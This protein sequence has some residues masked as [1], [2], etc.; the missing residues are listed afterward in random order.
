MSTT[1]KVIIAIVII[2]LIVGAIVWYKKSKAKPLAK[3]DKIDVGTIGT[4]G[5]EGTRA[6]AEV[7]R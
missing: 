2:L 3:S 7:I 5:A 6:M 1:A 4:A